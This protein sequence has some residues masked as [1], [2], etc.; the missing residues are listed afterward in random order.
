[1]QVFPP[2]PRYIVYMVNEPSRIRDS[3]KIISLNPLKRAGDGNFMKLLH[4]QF[5]EAQQRMRQVEGKG[6]EG[7]YTINPEPPQNIASLDITD[8]SPDKA[9]G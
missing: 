2:K 1:M 3:F 7:I 4:E 8:V 6:M 9:T 5:A